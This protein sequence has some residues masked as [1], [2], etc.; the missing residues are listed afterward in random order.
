MVFK[1]SNADV[2]PVIT[3]YIKFMGIS[4]S[5]QDGIK[6]KHAANLNIKMREICIVVSTVSVY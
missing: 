2:Q 6:L 5:P 3:G 4:S 1:Y